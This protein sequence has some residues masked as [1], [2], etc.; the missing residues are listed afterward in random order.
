VHKK[1][2]K[3]MND[4]DKEAFEDWLSNVD[5]S[6]TDALAYE[7]ERHLCFASWQAALA[8]RDKQIEEKMKGAC[9]TCE[10]VGELNQQLEAE[11][12][13]LREALNWCLSQVGYASPWWIKINEA[14]KEVGKK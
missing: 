9:P 4:K 2:G 5:N 6:Y 10:P 3:K 11:N 13:K 8:Y 7:F 12:K 1:F 14:L